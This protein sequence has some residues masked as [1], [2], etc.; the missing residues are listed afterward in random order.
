[1]EWRLTSPMR[2][3]DRDEGMVVFFHPATGNTHLLTDS[4]AALLRL[5]AS[6][7]LSEADLIDRFESESL[8]P[9]LEELEKLSRVEAI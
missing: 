1:M 6:K 8:A 3:Y 7:P 9:M 4:A 5:L 2:E